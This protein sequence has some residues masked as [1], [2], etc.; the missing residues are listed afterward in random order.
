[1]TVTYDS[2]IWQLSPQARQS[3]LASVAYG[4]MH[5]STFTLNVKPDQPKWIFEPKIEDDLFTFFINSNMLYF[6]VCLIALY[7]WLKKSKSCQNHLELCYGIQIM[8]ESW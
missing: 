1:M 5:F 4:K 3:L 7:V 8:L 2:N 6:I